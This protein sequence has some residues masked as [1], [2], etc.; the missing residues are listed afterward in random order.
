MEQ[1]LSRV[2]G[3]SAVAAEGELLFRQLT[4]EVHVFRLIRT[5]KG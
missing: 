5:R 4:V 1:G 3:S 2:E